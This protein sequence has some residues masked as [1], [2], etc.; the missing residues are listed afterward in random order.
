MT[1]PSLNNESCFYPW[2]KM[3]MSTKILRSQFYGK[4][5]D[6]ILTSIDIMEEL[7]KK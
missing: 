7:V 4:T 5:I 1:L 2:F 3:L 6:K